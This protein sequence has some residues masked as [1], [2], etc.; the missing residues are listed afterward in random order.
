MGYFYT[1]RHVFFVSENSEVRLNW[2]R[3]ELRSSAYWGE[4]AVYGTEI[5]VE[6]GKQCSL[7]V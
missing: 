2:K 7:G 3:P 1:S 5:I 6:P 4:I